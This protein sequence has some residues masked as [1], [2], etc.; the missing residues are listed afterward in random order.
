MAPLFWPGE[1]QRLLESIRLE[2]FRE[3]IEE[4]EYHWALRTLT[5]EAEKRQQID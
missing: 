5:A 4:F 3:G 2:L 1:D